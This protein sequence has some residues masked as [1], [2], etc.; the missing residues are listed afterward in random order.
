MGS[1][2]TPSKEELAW[3]QSRKALD[4][5]SWRAVGIADSIELC[6]SLKSGGG[7]RAPLVAATCF[8]DTSSNTFNFRFGQ[9]GITL[10][11]I[12]TITSLPIHPFAYCFGDF[13]GILK[14]LEFKPSTVRKPYSK[15]YTAWNAHFSTQENE[16]GGIAFLELWLCKFI[17]CINSAKITGTWTMLAAALFNGQQ[18]GIGQT[19]LASLYRSLYNLTLQPFDFTNSAGPLWIPDLWIQV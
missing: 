17:F 9:M 14:S 12:L 10:L 1:W 3:Y 5:E 8:W 18:T 4:F 6:F 7:N 13:N 19:V 11:D 16:E 2:P 15:S